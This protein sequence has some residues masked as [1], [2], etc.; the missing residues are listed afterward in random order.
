MVEIYCK[1]IISKRRTIDKVPDNFKMDVENRLK[2]LGYD[3][4]GDPLSK[5]V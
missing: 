1:L 3:V 5:E 2:E 4:N